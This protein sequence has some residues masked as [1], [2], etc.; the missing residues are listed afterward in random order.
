[1]DRAEFGKIIYDVMIDEYDELLVENVEH[2]F[3]PEFEKRMEK[4]ISRRKK[5]YFRM[6]NTVGKR[7]ACIAL[8]VVIASATTVMS[9]DALRN[10]V[11]KFIINT[12]SF[13]SYIKTEETSNNYPKTIEEIYDITYDLSGYHVIFED[14]NDVHRIKNYRNDENTVYFSQYTHDSYNLF[15]NTEGTEITHIDID[16]YDV[17]YYCDNHGYHTIIFDNGRYIFM[18]SVNSTKDEAINMMKSIQKVESK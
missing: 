15:I 9:V 2:E 18:L 13:G 11:F 8:V 4:L 5:P 7:V 1:M 16:G 17:M 6:I 12:F 3:S 10:A 14:N